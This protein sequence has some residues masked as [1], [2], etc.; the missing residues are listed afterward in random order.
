MQL[1]KYYFN[2]NDIKTLELI[3]NN[4]ID[5]RYLLDKILLYG[6]SKHKR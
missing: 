6:S 4:N 5:T 2:F 1:S 3:K